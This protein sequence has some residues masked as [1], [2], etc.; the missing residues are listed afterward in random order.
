MTP[1][2]VQ[3]EQTLWTAVE[4]LATSPDLPEERLR[5]AWLRVQQVVPGDLPERLL[6]AYEALSAQF[7]QHLAP[8]GGPSGL[9]LSRLAYLELS[10]ALC[11]FS[12]RLQEAAAG[13]RQ[14]DAGAT[15]IP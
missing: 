13:S 10:T 1:T 5:S 6:P 11:A 2:I 7:Q 15:R 4:I 12:R 8:E 9:P 3:A 14:A